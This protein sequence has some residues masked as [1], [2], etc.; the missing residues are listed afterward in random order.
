MKVLFLDIDGVLRTDSESANHDFNGKCVE[1][2]NK[3]I[4]KTDCEIVLTSD[5]RLYMTESEIDFIF[6]DNQAGSVSSI[7]IPGAKINNLF[8]VGA[9]EN[10]ILTTI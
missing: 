4:S 2:L 9:P 1:A 10:K 8:L 5:R 3:I 6:K 7:T